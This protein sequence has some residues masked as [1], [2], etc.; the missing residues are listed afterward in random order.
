[1]IEATAT[2][3]GGVPSKLAGIARCV[4]P[5]AAIK[6]AGAV[7]IAHAER[8]RR[9]RARQQKVTHQGSPPLAL[10]DQLAPE[11]TVPVKPL[12]WH[13]CRC[14]RPLPDWVRQDFLRRRIRRHHRTDRS[15]HGPYP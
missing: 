4:L 1:M 11:P 10:P 6:P 8:Q 14:H 5:V 7:V 9:Y 12:P 15:T 2:A 3:R 13:C